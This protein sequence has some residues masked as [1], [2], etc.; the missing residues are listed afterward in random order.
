M[1]TLTPFQSEQKST[2]SILADLKILN[3][4]TVEINFEWNDPEK[5]IVLSESPSGGRHF[6]LWQQTCFEAFIQPAGGA[7][8]YEINLSPAKAWNVFSFE[9]Y[10]A[11]QP[12]TEVPGVEILKFEVEGLAAGSTN[13]K[14]FKANLKV[15]I[16]I[17]GANFRQV[18][19]SLCSVVVLKDLQTTYWSTKHADQK[20][21]FHHFD[22]FTVERKST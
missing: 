7:K 19:A 20:A 8:Y 12:P 17:L 11:P 4:D 16:K 15:Q 22:S 14:T 21:N 6:N 3:S 5:K 9:S 10:R 18:N 1:L 13:L 2:V